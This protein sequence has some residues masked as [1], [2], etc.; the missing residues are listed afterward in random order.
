MILYASWNGATAVAQWRA[1]AGASTHALLPAATVARSGFETT[2]A[3]PTAP[4]FVEVQALD[5]DGQVLAG[6]AIARSPA[7]G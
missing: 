4:A 6:S 2:I 1:L 7:R 5:A 3:L